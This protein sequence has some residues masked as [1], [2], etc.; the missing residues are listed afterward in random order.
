MASADVQLS[1]CVLAGHRSR[2][3]A[4]IL[5]GFRRI[6]NEFGVRAG[7]QV[8]DEV[9]RVLAGAV[10]DGDIIEYLR[11][12]RVVVA[13]RRPTATTSPHARQRIADAVRSMDL[14]TILPVEPTQAP[15]LTVCIGAAGWPEDGRRSV[16]L[17][18]TGRRPAQ[19]REVRGR[20]RLCVAFDAVTS[21][22]AALAARTQ[23]VRNKRPLMNDSRGAQRAGTSQRDNHQPPTSWSE[24][25]EPGSRCP[26]AE[27]LE[28]AQ[29]E[30]VD[31]V[32]FARRL[33]E[34]RSIQIRLLPGRPQRRVGSCAGCACR[35]TLA[36]STSTTR[37]QGRRRP[38]N[39]NIAHELGHIVFGHQARRRPS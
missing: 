30:V 24:L 28:P 21:E 33:V 36:S 29:G 38:L 37:P 19:H 2:G 9:T 12:L 35:S 26:Q 3:I 25:V 8:L 5:D 20:G 27:G 14:S 17:L 13:A 34:A 32:D 4:V 39:H 18:L 31:L 1:C 11:R 22:T 16:D 10:R 7:D 6:N 15:R 23:A